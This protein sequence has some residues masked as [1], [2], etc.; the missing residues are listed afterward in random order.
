MPDKLVVFNPQGYPPKV[1]A[2]GMAPSLEGGLLG[3]TLF[4]VD[5]GFEN[6][7]VFMAELQAVLAERSPSTHTV[8]AHWRDERQADPELCRQIKEE[9]DGVVIGVGT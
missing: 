2:R 6:S 4:L 1:T 7:D 3:K 5:T 8:L 9:G